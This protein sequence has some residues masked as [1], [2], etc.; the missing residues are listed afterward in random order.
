MEDDR[1]C[2]AHPQQKGEEIM[3]RWKKWSMMAMVLVLFGWG[4]IAC[5]SPNAIGPDKVFESNQYQI[6]VPSI[7]GLACTWVRLD[8]KKK[9]VDSDCY[10]FAMK[11]LPPKRIKTSASCYIKK[12]DYQNKKVVYSC[13]CDFEE[14]WNP[15]AEPPKEPKSESMMDSHM[16]G[17][18][19]DKT[20]DM[21]SEPKPEPMMEP[22][23]DGGM[24]DDHMMDKAPD[25]MMEPHSE[26]MMD[27]HMDGGS[28]DMMSDSM[29]DK[30]PDMPSCPQ[31]YSWSK[32]AMKCIKDTFINY[33]PKEGEMWLF[34]WHGGPKKGVVMWRS[35]V[36]NSTMACMGM[37]FKPSD[38]MV[39][40]R[41][42]DKSWNCMQIPNGTSFMMPKM[43][44][45]NGVT[46]YYVELFVGTEEVEFLHQTA[47]KTYMWPKCHH[48]DPKYVFW[49]MTSNK[50][51]S[52]GDPW[53]AH[54]NNMT[55]A[56]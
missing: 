14:D 6:T 41:C 10:C 21:M 31:G 8:P 26:P 24:A 29:M 49:M 56:P 47:S 44:T 13:S 45:V 33:K 11:G 16:D 34:Y 32:D 37:N 20:P 46:F 3:S 38:L 12:W 22:A 1:Q 43:G 23:M 48:G 54:N 39:Q 7:L 42:F 50:A 2:P 51:H 4:A 17:G 19:M 30:M 28:G 52:S 35:L 36:P 25:M 5:N 27:M 15:P 55:P 18:M 40:A 53:F 9:V